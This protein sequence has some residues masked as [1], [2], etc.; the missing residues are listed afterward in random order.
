MTGDK[1]SLEF[2]N[3]LS[4][5]DSL[6]C[7]LEEYGDTLGLTKKALFQIKFSL[8]EIFVNIISY[9]FIDDKEHKINVTIT[10]EHDLIVLRIE[11]DGIP[12]NP[13]EADPPDLE[14]PLEERCTGGLGL[15]LTKKL[16]NDISYERK[17]NKNILTMKKKIDEP[18]LSACG[19]S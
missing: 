3:D 10:R 1:I 18:C 11:D 8:E 5:L 2:K 14:S 12:F 4:E 15:H 19:P 16:M 6:V 9:G 7:C 13:L 17:G